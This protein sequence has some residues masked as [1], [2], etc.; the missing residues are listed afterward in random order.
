[1]KL[2]IVGGGPDEKN[3]K[4]LVND[5]KLD[6][7]IFTGEI[8]NEDI[9]YYYRLGTAFITNSI[10]ETQGLTVIEA[11][12][13]S[14]PVICVNSPLYDKVVENGKNG[15]K[16]SNMSEL[17]KVLSQLYNNREYI[18]RMRKYTEL[19]VFKYSI[20]HSTKKIV[21]IYDDEISKKNLYGR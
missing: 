19:S 3:L 17:V 1:M 2:L 16:Y 6:N 12:A 15:I 14:I 21:N 10:A 13:S 20:E 7:V 4:K 5:L 11:L 9:A 8:A 18:E